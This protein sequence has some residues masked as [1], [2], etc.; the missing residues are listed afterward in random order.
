MRDNLYKRDFEESTFDPIHPLVK[1][2]KNCKVGY[3][4]AIQEGCEIGDDCIIGNNT[5]I[6]KNVK[7]GDRVI[8]SHNVVIE[9][10]ARIGSHVTI[11]A[12]THLTKDIII[13]DDVFFGPN[14]TTSN[15]R[16]IKHGRNFPLTIEAPHIKRAVRVGAGATITPGVTIGENALIGAGAVVTKDISACKIALGVPARE[17]GDVPEEE[18][19]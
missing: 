19:L 18:L 5:T 17:V 9:N 6:C 1:F 13:E 7:M 4:V 3:G 15:T 14:A 11:H 2:G 12:Q 8:I 16:K 10:G